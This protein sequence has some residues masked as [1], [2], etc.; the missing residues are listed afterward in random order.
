MKKL[1]LGR[2]GSA[3]ATALLFMVALATL[4]LLLLSAVTVSHSIARRGERELATRLELEQIGEYFCIET[5]EAF[6]AREF[7]EYR[8]ETSYAEEN[9]A[10][11]N[12]LRVY[13]SREKVILYIEAKDGA[14][15][16]WRYSEPA[17]P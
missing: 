4:S 13:N 11:N 1:L 3:M 6:S 2:R 5:E 12:I 16:L 7:S 15:V 10:V 17:V 8:V 9:E 14:A